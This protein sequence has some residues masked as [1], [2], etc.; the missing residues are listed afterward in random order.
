M[1]ADAAAVQ[2]G[3]LYVHGGGW[4]RIT[5][6]SLPWVHPTLALAFIL[7]IEYLEALR[8]HPVTIELLDDDE[9]LVFPKIE[10]SVRVGHPPTLAAGSPLFVPQAIT[11]NSLQF[12]KHGT[13]RFRVTAGGSVA[14]VPF[15]VSP[16][17]PVS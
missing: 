1:I 10:G 8:D 9:Q 13:Y 12:A 4:D 7:R 2:G 15:Y 11:L 3:K 5:T 6:A 16:P 17:P 14:E